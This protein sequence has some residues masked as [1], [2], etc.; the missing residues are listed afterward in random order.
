[1]QVVGE[2]LET[3]SAKLLFGLQLRFDVNQLVIGETLHIGK[4]DA[5]ERLGISH[6]DNP[7]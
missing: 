6:G 7:C 1:M 3:A 5:L 2:L 4:V